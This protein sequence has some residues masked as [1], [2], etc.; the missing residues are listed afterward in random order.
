[1]TLSTRCGEKCNSESVRIWV[2]PL[3]RKKCRVRSNV[4]T[5]RMI[6]RPGD[7]LAILERWSRNSQ[8]FG[9]T[10][11]WPSDVGVALYGVRTR[12]ETA[13][14]ASQVKSGELAGLLELTL[15]LQKLR[16]EADSR[17]TESKGLVEW[18]REQPDIKRQILAKHIGGTYA[19]ILTPAA[20]SA[21]SEIATASP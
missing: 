5:I 17:E 2:N 20:I 21:L 14:V 16:H 19:A 13:E 9:D 1:M 11:I 8:R 4:L 6:P 10:V 18:I 15:R 3:D 7:E 12:K